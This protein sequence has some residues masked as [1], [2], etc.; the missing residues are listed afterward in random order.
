MVTHI[1]R[2]VIADSP[3]RWKLVAPTNG[4]GAIASMLN[5]RGAT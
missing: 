3:F 1:M 4:I 2:T 5:C